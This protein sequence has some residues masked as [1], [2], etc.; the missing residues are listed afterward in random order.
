M[1]SRLQSILYVFKYKKQYATLYNIPY[2][3]QCCTCF[4]RF[5]RT[6][7]GAQKL[8]A[9]TAKLGEFPTLAVEAS[10]LD[11]YPMLHVQFLSS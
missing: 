5:L 10:K 4:G 2:Y 1:T 7:S 3:C 9:A 6:S 11:I 8:L